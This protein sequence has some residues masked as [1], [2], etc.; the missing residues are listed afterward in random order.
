MTSEPAARSGKAPEL[1]R[2][3]EKEKF[4]IHVRARTARSLA[5]KR[6]G[7]R[8]VLI[9]FF[10]VRFCW[11]RRLRHQEP[12]RHRQSVHRAGKPSVQDQLVLAGSHAFWRIRLPDP[13]PEVP[14]PRE[15][16]LGAVQPVE[17]VTRQALASSVEGVLR[18]AK[19]AH[20]ETR[21]VQQLVL[22]Q[23]GADS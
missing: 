20:S 16:L 3:I 17:P 21:K 4:G 19:Q 2:R 22:G 11:F 1:V 9:G 10:G 14:Y 18:P 5:W 7:E 13:L 12:W 6:L 8:I 23:L 15:C